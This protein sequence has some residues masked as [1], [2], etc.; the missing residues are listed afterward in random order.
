MFIV[1]SLLIFQ[2]FVITVYNTANKTYRMWANFQHTR[3]FDMG[4]FWTSGN[5]CHRGILDVDD[6]WTWAS[7]RH[8]RVLDVG[9]F[10]GGQVLYLGEIWT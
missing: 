7:F 5:F 8:G 9:E 4:E 2:H 1:D 10:G 6:F 3:V